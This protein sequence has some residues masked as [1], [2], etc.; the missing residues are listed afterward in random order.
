MDT[1]IFQDEDTTA[2]KYTVVLSPEIEEAFIHIEKTDGSSHS[3]IAP[4]IDGTDEVSAILR[5][6]GFTINGYQTATIL[7]F[8]RPEIVDTATV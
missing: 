5:Q 8:K 7:P 3:A 4:I 2:G 6:H 1:S